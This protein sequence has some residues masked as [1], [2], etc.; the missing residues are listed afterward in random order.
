MERPLRWLA[1]AALMVAA[2]CLLVGMVAYRWEIVDSSPA[3]LASG[4]VYPWLA[5]SVVA[6]ALYV[7]AS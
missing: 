4:F 3:T 2:L 7:T 1:I 5:V 6:L